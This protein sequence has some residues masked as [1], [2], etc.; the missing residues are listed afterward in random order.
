MFIAGIVLN[1]NYKFTNYDYLQGYIMERHFGGRYSRFSHF[2]KSLED[3]GFKIDQ[4]KDTTTDY[5][6]TPI[7]AKDHFGCWKVKW[8]Q[9]TLDKCLYLLKGFLTDPFLMHRWIYYNND[10]WQWQFGTSC[11]YKKPLTKQ[12]VNNAPA[13]NKWFLCSK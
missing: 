5:A 13:Q 1:E 6:Y 10:T 12:Q 9:D 2:K 8:H 7:I 4:I 3:S 11:S